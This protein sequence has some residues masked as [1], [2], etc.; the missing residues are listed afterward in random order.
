MSA[1][2]QAGRLKTCTT[3]IRNS[4]HGRLAPPTLRGVREENGRALE[5]S[6]DGRAAVFLPLNVS[7]VSDVSAGAGDRQASAM[8][9]GR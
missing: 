2:G 6:L 4:W 8:R 3:R 7:D 1:T 5:F 9:G